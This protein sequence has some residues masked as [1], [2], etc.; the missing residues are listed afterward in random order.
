[1][2][3]LHGLAVPVSGSKCSEK[4]SPT[5]GGSPFAYP[6]VCP[7]PTTGVAEFPDH[8]LHLRTLGPIEAGCLNFGE[9]LFLF[10][11]SCFMI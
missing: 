4:V 6:S 7:H 2:V 10:S 1:M 3:P 5:E 8:H 9:Y 11:V